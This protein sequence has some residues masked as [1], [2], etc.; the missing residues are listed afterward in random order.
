MAGRQ[1][2]PKAEGEVRT[3]TYLAPGQAPEVQRDEPSLDPELAEIRD[4]EAEANSVDISGSR[5]DISIDDE[6]VKARDEQIKRETDLASGKV[7]TDTAPA[8]KAPAK[9]SASKK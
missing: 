9:K 3:I 1:K 4:R 5:E 6:L 2:A 8:K 7:S